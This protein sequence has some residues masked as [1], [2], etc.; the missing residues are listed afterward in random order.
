[1][2]VEEILKKVDYL[3]FF[4]SSTVESFYKGIE[5]NISLI[6]DKKIVSIGPVTSETLRS[7]GIK[8]DI[9]AEIYDTDGVI[10]AI[11]GE[12]NV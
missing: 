4:S 3:T 8:V 6:K 2:D 10:S 1:E 11:R 12:K 5:E 9:E 7:F